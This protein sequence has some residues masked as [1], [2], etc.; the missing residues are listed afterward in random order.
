MADPNITQ[1]P[2]PRVDFIDPRTGL[3]SRQWYRFFLN[4]FNLTG[5]DSNATSISDLQVGPLSDVAGLAAIQAQ[6]TALEVAPAYQDQLTELTKTVQDLSLTPT[7]LPVYPGDGLGSIQYNN[8]GTFGG[9]TK[10]IY[11]GNST[12][13]AGAAASGISSTSFNFNG[14]AGT[15]ATLKNGSNVTFQ[16]GNAYSVSGSGAGGILS[17]MGGAGGP[18]GTGGQAVIIG[19]DGQ[20]GGDASLAA[21]N[22]VSGA[23]TGGNFTGNAGASVGG[24]GG[25]IV[26]LPGTGVTQ[27]ND[28]T[29]TFYT[30]QSVSGVYIDQYANVTLSTPQTVASLI[31]AATAGAGARSFVTNA[32]APVFG[33]TVVGGGAVNVPVYSD[34][35]NWKVG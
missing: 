21:G 22:S 32:L 25:S 33:N 16:G 9:S 27:A 13:T 11:D 30:A 15:S 20:N 26:W 28:G 31:S 7:I 4:L 23:G 34:G 8:N 1:I 19:G 29:T 18:T 35:T 24:T 3:M 2:A 6:S 12:V 5:G 14:A 10:F 17:F